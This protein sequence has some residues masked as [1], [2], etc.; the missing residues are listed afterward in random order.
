[1]FW[2]YIGLEVVEKVVYDTPKL[3]SSIISS[4]SQ[5]ET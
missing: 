2:D 1:M 5:Q 4:Y 3:M